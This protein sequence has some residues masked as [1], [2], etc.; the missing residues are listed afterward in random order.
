[1]PEPSLTDDRT[2]V[3]RAAA[4]LPVQEID[5][6][7]SACR[8]EMDGRLAMLT[9]DALA[10]SGSMLLVAALT[11]ARFTLWVPA[12]LPLFA[13]LAKTAGLYDRDQ[14]VLH[15]TT[16]DETPALLAAGAIFSLFIEATQAVQFTG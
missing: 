11:G 8:R 6:P 1:M 9:A 15:K 10:V 5:I 16:L 7:P 2:W 12:F 3:A 14:Y 4:D 13:L